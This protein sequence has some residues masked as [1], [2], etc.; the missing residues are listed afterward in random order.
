MISYV[1]DFFS[2]GTSIYALSS[3]G[4]TIDS[5]ALDAVAS[6][7]AGLLRFDSSFVNKKDDVASWYQ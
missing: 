1:C 4:K 2:S 7:Y 6:K 5:K 3:K